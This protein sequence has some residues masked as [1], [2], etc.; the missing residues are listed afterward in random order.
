MAERAEDVALEAVYD[1]YYGEMVGFARGWLRQAGVPESH[2]DAEDVV[3][4]AFAKA[5]RDPGRIKEPRRYLYRVIK[6]Q[7]QEHE[8]RTQRADRAAQI[9]A[10]PAVACVDELVVE[11]CDVQRALGRLP[12]Q[13]RT[14]VFAAKALEFTQAEVAQIMGKRPGTVAVHIARG[15]Q[16]LRAALVTT[17]A[18]AAVIL[19]VGAATG[20]RLISTAAGT[21]RQLPD[22]GAFLNWSGLVAWLAVAAGVGLVAVLYL[23]AHRLRTEAVA[24]RTDVTAV[25]TL[26][27]YLPNFLASLCVLILLSAFLGKYSVVMILAWLASGA[28]MFHRPT[29]SGIARYLLRL[30]HPTPQERARLESLWR[31]VTARAG[32][33]P[34]AY[35]LWVEDSNH[36]NAIP[37][38]GHIVSVT[39]F[40][41]NQLSDREVAAVLAH[42]LGHQV[43]GHAW[44]SLLGYW[45]ALPGR[46]LW[47]ILRSILG[48][49]LKVFIPFGILGTSAVLLLIGSLAVVAVISFFGL[50]LI[51]VVVPFMLAYVGR[52]AELHADQFAASLG[53]GPVLADVLKKLQQQTQTASGRGAPVESRLGKLLASEPDYD[54]RLHLLDPHRHPE[55]T[56]EAVQGPTSA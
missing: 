42:E 56:D 32:L 36:L 9:T 10:P 33:K 7:L 47:R 1:R 46:I 3:Q 52:R 27:L 14:A 53:F 23:S 4:S 48:F 17:A 6:N 5:W 2:V 18:V 22:L 30:R 21:G 20:L 43:S 11:I 8:E 51:L 26:L 19:C 25:G 35:E 38:A 40:A 41:L 54:N 44:P 24:P 34:C 16:A 12:V 45:Y 50:P 28:L 15:V 37:A 39:S 55:T 29:G 49:L 13:Q 31:D